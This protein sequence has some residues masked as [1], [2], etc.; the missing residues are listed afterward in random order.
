[1]GT[2]VYFFVG[3]VVEFVYPKSIFFASANVRSV[4]FL[5]IVLS[6]P[7]MKFSRCTLVLHMELSLHIDGNAFSAM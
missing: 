3:P 6:F 5:V 2:Y 1:M 7:V 4:C